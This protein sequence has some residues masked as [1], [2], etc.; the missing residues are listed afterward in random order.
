[1]VMSSLVSVDQTCAVP[2]H[3][4]LDNCHLL[5]CISDYADQK[6]MHVAIICL[7]Q[8]KT[9]DHVLHEFLFSC[10]EAYGFGPDFIR[11]VHLLYTNTPSSVLINGY[12]SDPFPVCRSVHQGCGL[13]PLLCMLS[14]VSCLFLVRIWTTG[15]KG[16]LNLKGN[17]EEHI[18]W[19][20]QSF[21]LREN[22]KKTNEGN[23]YRDLMKRYGSTY[24]SYSSIW[25]QI[26]TTFYVDF[27]SDDSALP[28]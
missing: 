26:N 24:N 28:L 4:I 10:L 19:L 22:L 11:W 6:D 15:G 16:T 17:R 9:F 27:L 1:M 20:K 3:S 13:S 2:G 8:R 7:D 12:I 5:W 23:T 14:I 25:F 18:H 21:N